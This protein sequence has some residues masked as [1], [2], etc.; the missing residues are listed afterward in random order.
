MDSASDFKYS[1]LGLFFLVYFIL[2][3]SASVQLNVTFCFCDE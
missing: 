1:S 2:F 3:L